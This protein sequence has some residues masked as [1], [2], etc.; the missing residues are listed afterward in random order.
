[1]LISSSGGQEAIYDL[2]KSY[3]GQLELPWHNHFPRTIS[4]GTGKLD[5]CTGE[6]KNYRGGA[7]LHVR[8]VSGNG[9]V[10]FRAGPYKAPVLCLNKS[11]NN[12]KYLMQI[13]VWIE[14]DPNSF[15]FAIK[16]V[17]VPQQNKLFSIEF[18]EG[19]LSDQN[20]RTFH[21]RVFFN[22][23]YIGYVQLQRRH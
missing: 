7:N 1:V 14:E 20:V 21:G 17:Q 23:R 13:P 16:S 22:H 6:C 2:M 9:T 19:R 15:G 4:C 5:R 18:D 10:Q 11:E 12:S 3:T 8:I